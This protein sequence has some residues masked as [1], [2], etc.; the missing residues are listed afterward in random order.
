MAEQ[1]SRAP[2]R[3]SVW[4]GEGSRKRSGNLVQKTPSSEKLLTLRPPSEG[5]AARTTPAEPRPA[6]PL[7]PFLTQ[8]ATRPIV[9][10]P[11]VRCGDTTAAAAASLDSK[12]GPPRAAERRRA[13]PRPQGRAEVITDPTLQGPRPPSVSSVEEHYIYGTQCDPVQRPCGKGPPS[14]N[15]IYVVHATKETFIVLSLVPST[16]CLETL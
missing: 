15:F 10:E 12:P 1:S 14:D 4:V 2:R 16:N 8:P 3:G 5:A 13:P 7:C 11:V 9:K 6:S